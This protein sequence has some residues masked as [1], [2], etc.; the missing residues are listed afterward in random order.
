M[1]VAVAGAGVDADDEQPTT[2]DSPIA[3]GA[4]RT[5]ALSA[6]GRRTN[7]SDFTGELRL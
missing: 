5:R 6:P 3:S 4:V 1:G 7:D 2:Q